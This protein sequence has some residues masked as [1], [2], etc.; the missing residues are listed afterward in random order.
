MKNH[1][2]PVNGRTA[3]TLNNARSKFTWLF[4]GTPANTPTCTPIVL[5]TEADTETE[6]RE[7]FPAWSLTFAAKIRTEC[8][9]ADHRSGV[10]VFDLMEVRH[11]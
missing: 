2:T 5:R 8:A 4:I 9:V 7:R 1:T 3:Y 6:A 11:A 10:V